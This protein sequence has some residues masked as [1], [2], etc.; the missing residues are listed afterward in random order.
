MAPERLNPRGEAAALLAGIRTYITGDHRDGA[1][2][3]RTG[4]MIRRGME[5]GS[6]HPKHVCGMTWT[7]GYVVARVQDAADGTIC[8]F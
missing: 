5:H 1:T 3:M 6:V 7:S 8:P 4:E 2:R